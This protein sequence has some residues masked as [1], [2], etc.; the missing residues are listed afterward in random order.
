[1]NVYLHPYQVE[2]RFFLAHRRFALLADEMGLGKTVQTIAAANAASTKR[3]LVLCPATARDNWRNEFNKFDDSISCV[4][5]RS[6]KDL[7]RELQAESGG[8]KSLSGRGSTTGG[9]AARRAIITTYDLA[10]DLTPAELQRIGRC[11]LLVLDE[12]H[13]LKSVDATRTQRILA[14]GGL[15]EHCQ[16]IWALTGTPMP[17]HPGELWPL[18][19]TFGVTRLSYDDFVTRFCET[20]PGFRGKL[21]VVGRNPERDGA[22][23]RMLKVI[24]L[25]RTAEEVG[26]Q[27][28]PLSIGDLVV[29]AGKVIADEGLRARAAEQE[30]WLRERLEGVN[31]FEPQHMALL[32][33]VAESVSTLRLYNG[34]QKVE[35]IS[36]LVHDELEAGAYRK[37]IIFAI[38]T[39]VIYQ[40]AENLMQWG[41][42]TL[43]GATPTQARALRIAQFQQL[44]DVQ[45]IVC[46]IKAAGTA[47][48][49]TEADQVLFAESEW[50]PGD[51]RQ[52]LKRA[53][54]IG[55]KRPVFARFAGISGSID[56][57]IQ[58]I[59]RRKAA[60]IDA[61]IGA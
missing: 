59:N 44:E 23:K 31:V 16:R 34:L 22:L 40:L 10:A 17:N 21:R 49:L 60:D 55:R 8:E 14:R 7:V 45:V 43:N 46:N 61:I 36:D 2:G 35:P 12:A 20:I 26:L 1:M 18:L 54:R 6:K 25:R 13:M 4:V 30:E 41:A 42:V 29:P 28:P 3:L 32:E 51:N 38:H 15:R 9:G 27:L 53:H 56:Q 5:A 37:I 39:S 48:N 50:S 19:R 33:S 11:D 58:Q 52:A 24:M 47:I 57:R